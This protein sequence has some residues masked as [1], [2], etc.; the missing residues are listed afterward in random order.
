MRFQDG[1]P[2]QKVLF[3]A[4]LGVFAL[5]ATVTVQDKLARVGQPDIGWRLD[6]ANLSPTRWDA[7]AE[8][9]WAGGR[10]LWINGI[11]PTGRTLWE[12]IPQSIRREVGEANRVTLRH[13]SGRV[14]EVTV[15]V[16]PLQWADVLFSEGTT[17]GLGVL[18]FIVGVTGFVVRPY[19]A[20]SWALLAMCTV[21]GSLLASLFL[22]DSEND[23]LREL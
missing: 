21:F 2:R 23:A 22:Q 10:A 5:A 14:S 7:A 11:E 1:S 9:L 3:T 15:S 18:F 20:T 13:P 12:E 19:A 6:G 4:L 16:Q 8:G 17:I